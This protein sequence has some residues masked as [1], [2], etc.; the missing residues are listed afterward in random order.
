MSNESFAIAL[1]ESCY[2]N[3]RNWTPAVPTPGPIPVQQCPV[4]TVGPLWSFLIFSTVGHRSVCFDT[5]RGWVTIPHQKQNV[6]VLANSNEVGEY[7]IVDVYL[8]NGNVV[9]HKSVDY[10]R[11]LK[12][13]RALFDTG[14]GYIVPESHFK[15]PIIDQ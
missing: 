8:S 6:V 1:L 7:T 14:V 12:I 13:L 3:W 9:D 4:H 10:A 15:I 5:L 2:P 11:R